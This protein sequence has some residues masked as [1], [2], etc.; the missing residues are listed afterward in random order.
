MLLKPIVALHI[1]IFFLQVV[2]IIWGGGGND[3]FA[4]LIFSL[5]AT[6]PAPQ[7]RRLYS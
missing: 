6:A 4:P 3:M 1:T 5:G 7:D 2:E